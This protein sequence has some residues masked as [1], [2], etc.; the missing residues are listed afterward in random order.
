MSDLL[1]ILPR[2]GRSNVTTLF[3]LH[4]ADHNALVAAINSLH[5]GVDGWVS[6]IHLVRYVTD[7]DREADM[8][9]PEGTLSWVVS[10]RTLS[11]KYGDAWL[12]LTQPRQVFTPRCWLGGTE[13]VSVST[14][15]YESTFSQEFGLCYF[16]ICA[17]FNFVAGSTGVLSVL[18]PLQPEDDIA[19]PFQNAYV[20]VPDLGAVGGMG[21]GWNGTTPLAGAPY[22]G[23]LAVVMP[24][25]DGLL[26]QGHMGDLTGDH[27]DVFMA[28]CFPLLGFVT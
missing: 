19:A 23:Q 5:A 13:Q 14:A 28:G 18:P 16:N 7:A 24:G 2:P 10:S 3:D 8:G 9:Q 25:G 27:F 20:V 26:D 17:R 1:D 22:D 11:V 15:T 4:P 6:T 21:G 12:T